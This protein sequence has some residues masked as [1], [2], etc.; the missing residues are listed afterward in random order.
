MII[1]HIEYLKFLQMAEDTLTTD[2]FLGLPLP[3]PLALA[4]KVLDLHQNE[5]R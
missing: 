2:I 5:D 1:L 3:P 4:V